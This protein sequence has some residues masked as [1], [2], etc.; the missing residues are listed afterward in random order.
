[1]VCVY[2][3]VKW[4]SENPLIMDMLWPVKRPVK[5]H[6]IIEGWPLIIWKASCYPALCE[7]VDRQE[8]VLLSMPTN[9]SNENWSND[10]WQTVCVLMTEKVIG[11]RRQ[12]LQCYY[13]NDNCDQPEEMDI[14]PNYYSMARPA[15]WPC[16]GQLDG[17]RTLPSN[18]Y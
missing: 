18:Y 17:E 3:C 15:G 9:E 10:R 7:A 12:W 16:G 13:W 2:Y 14:Q 5:T 8:I 1:M 4:P 11:R 6:C